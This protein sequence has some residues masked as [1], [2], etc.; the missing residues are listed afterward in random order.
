MASKRSF[1]PCSN[2]LL[3]IKVTVF[4]I[5]A[6]VCDRVPLIFDFLFDIPMDVLDRASDV[7]GSQPQSTLRSPTSSFLYFICVVKNAIKINVE[8]NYF[9]YSFTTDTYINKFFELTITSRQ[10]VNPTNCT[11]RPIQDFKTNFCFEVLKGYNK[12]ILKI[13]MRRTTTC[14]D[15]I[16]LS[17]S[18]LCEG[19]T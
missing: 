8:D 17:P 1:T 2:K 3:K 9:M 13:E 7:T 12:D 18:A 5:A 4:K 19:V 14:I 11:H 6:A 15:M 10:C 16:Q